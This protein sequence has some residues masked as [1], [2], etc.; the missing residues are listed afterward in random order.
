VI[1]TIADRAMIVDRVT[2]TTRVTKVRTIATVN[3]AVN[4]EINPVARAMIVMIAMTA[5]VSK[6]MDVIVV[7]AVVV[8]AD[9]KK[10]LRVKIAKAQPSAPG[11]AMAAALRKVA[12]LFHKKQ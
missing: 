9:A 2:T 1:A 11:T 12:N 8:R 10:V 4:R 6:V 3:R 5:T 7:V